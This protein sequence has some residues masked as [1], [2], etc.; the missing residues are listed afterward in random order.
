MIG[1]GVPM[2]TGDSEA[3]RSRGIMV[4][5]E[6][7]G[8]EDREGG[9]LQL[10]MNISYKSALSKAEASSSSL[11]LSRGI[12]L[13]VVDRSSGYCMLSSVSSSSCC[14]SNK[15]FVLPGAGAAAAGLLPA[16]PVALLGAWQFDDW[17]QRP[18]MLEKWLRHP[19]H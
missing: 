11:W 18:A 17:S 15:T 13:S 14:S 5:R 8:R 10:A 9:L 4:V 16:V 6:E 2:E 12:L 1:R 19:W 7:E 3:A